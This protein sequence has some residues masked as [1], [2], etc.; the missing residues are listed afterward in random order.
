ML[1]DFHY[2]RRACLGFH[3]IHRAQMLGAAN[4]FDEPRQVHKAKKTTF[5][6]R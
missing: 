4:S 6:Q 1:L 3:K 5:N 2:K